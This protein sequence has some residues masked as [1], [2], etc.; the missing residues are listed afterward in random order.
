MT[1]HRR[2]GVAIVDTKKGF[3]WFLQ[4]IMSLY[5]LAEG[6]KMGKQEKS[7]NKRTL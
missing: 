5:F 1:Y 4:G 7:Y 3:Y 2:K 6:W